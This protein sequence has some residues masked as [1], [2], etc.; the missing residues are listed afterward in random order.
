MTTTATDVST[1]SREAT[2]HL[3]ASAPAA[4]V[5]MFRVYWT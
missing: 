1:G 5:T 3:P 2:V 4:A